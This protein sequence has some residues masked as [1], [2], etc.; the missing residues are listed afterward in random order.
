M[1]V[2]GSGSKR[3][4]IYPPMVPAAREWLKARCAVDDSFRE[5]TLMAFVE[6]S[7]ANLTRFVAYLLQ[8]ELLQVGLSRP[9]TF[10]GHRGNDTQ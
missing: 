9:D 2:D 1:D 6:P 7:E 4:G 5:L 3:S 10:G 8:F